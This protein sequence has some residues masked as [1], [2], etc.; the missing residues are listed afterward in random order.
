MKMTRPQESAEVVGQQGVLHDLA[1][2]RASGDQPHPHHRLGASSRAIQ[3]ASPS[4][5]AAETSRTSSPGRTVW[6]FCSSARRS[7]R[8]APARS[9]FVMTAIRGIEN[10]RILLRLSSA[11][12]T[13]SSTTRKCSPR[14][15]AETRSPTFSMN[16]LFEIRPLPS[17]ERASDHVGSE[18]LRHPRTPSANLHERFRRNPAIIRGVTPSR[19]R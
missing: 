11:S 17:L 18:V 6:M 10:R 4:P 1:S 5:V 9:R 19:S 12:V 3:D 2:Y 14:S 8:T 16:K 7:N 15:Y 13:D